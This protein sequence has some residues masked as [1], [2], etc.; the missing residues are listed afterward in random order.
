MTPA[1]P[2]PLAVVADRVGATASL[3]CAVHCALLPFV[4]TVLPLIG[5][6]FLAG[7]AFERVFVACAALL[8]GVSIL[9]A[10][11][12]HHR[13][14]ALFL[15]VPGIALLLLGIA[16]DLDVHVAIHTASVVAGGVLLASAHFT[17]LVLSHRHRAVCPT[18]PA[19][20]P[21]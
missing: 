13:P 4:L 3:L 2:R 21:A 6:G 14:H 8:A 20:V 16:V 18:R 5:L 7:H 15:M 19:G 10:Y 9:T 1:A 12:R 11:R 17:N